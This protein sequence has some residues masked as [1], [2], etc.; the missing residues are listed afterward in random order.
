[1]RHI[2]IAILIIITTGGCAAQT[3]QYTERTP[4]GVYQRDVNRGAFHS[5]VSETWDSKEEYEDC[6]ATVNRRQLGGLT[7]DEYCRRQTNSDRRQ[8]TQS[9]NGV[10]PGGPGYTVAP[11]GGALPV[12][13]M[14]AYPMPMLQAPPGQL[15][16]EGTQTDYVYSSQ[17]EAAHRRATVVP[18]GRESDLDATMRQV[19]QDHNALEAHKA[20]EHRH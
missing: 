20:D 1:M 3:Y 10:A 16:Y 17:V 13:G 11:M 6:L 4:D 9:S 5:H 19:S 2:L 18:S 14:G 15:D 8:Q 12:T 7:A